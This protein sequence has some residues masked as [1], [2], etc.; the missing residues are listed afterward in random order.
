[1]RRLL[2]MGTAREGST[3]TKDKMTRK[4]GSTT[5]Y[6]LYLKKFEDILHM[7]HPFN[8][9]IMAINKNDKLLWRLSENSEVKIQERSDFSAKDAS[10]PADI[11][12]YLQN[13]DE[14]YVMWV[15]ACFPFLKPK[16]I[17]DAAQMFI[18][19]ENMKSFHC[20]KERQNWFWD[21]Q[22]KK[23]ITLE[24]KSHT[25]TQESK[26]IYESVHCFLIHNI[27][28]ILN[29]N[30]LWDFKLNDPYLHVVPDTLEFFDIDTEEEFN[31]CE[32]LWNADN[33]I[34]NQKII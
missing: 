24:K 14:E 3:R 1:M 13:Y 34:V 28:T 23:P 12:E 30:K 6:E 17:I 5:L 11:Y 8:E 33:Q 32:T 9:I 21:P 4:F 25:M 31:I 7:V 29:E 26:V 10:L 22:T 2:L 16:T 27:N 15:N 20:V 18:D 19:D